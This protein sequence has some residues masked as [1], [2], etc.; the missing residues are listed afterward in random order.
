MTKR[1]RPRGETIRKFLLS[2][3]E[4]GVPDVARSTA[5]K[6]DISRQA[7]NKHL[8]R[9]EDERAILRSGKTR[10]SSYRLAPL[11]ESEFF[12]D[13]GRGVAEDV[14]WRTDIKPLLEPLPDTVQNIWSY[15]VTEIIN[16]AVDHSEGTR[17]FVRVERTATSTEIVI[18]D[19]GRGIFQK[20][21]AEL[22]LLDVRHAVLELSKGKLTTDPKNHTGEGIFFTSRMMDSFDIQSGDVALSHVFGKPEDWILEAKIPF[23]GT[24]VWMKLD[25]HTA[26]TTLQIFDQYQSP[27]DRR[28]DK[29]VVPVRL[30]QY[31]HDQL[32]SRSQAK[33][34]LA[35]VE[36]FQQVLFDFSGVEAV[37][38]AFADEIFRVF[39]QE[40]PEMELFPINANDLVGAMIQ[41]AVLDRG[42]P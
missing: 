1:V 28:F 32:L 3:I 26:R 42:G 6:F 25:N 16:N 15:G 10:G 13:I 11:Q 33:R 34:V 24:A 35:R 17:L 36:L 41:K 22:G 4:A 29:T 23:S 20:I 5:E 31:G 39:A 27:E 12:Y 38:P 37:G 18:A 14:I 19:N 7:V 9:L 21:Q 8:R 2:Q 30:A 40:H